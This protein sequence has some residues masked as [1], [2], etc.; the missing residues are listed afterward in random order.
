M[1][2]ED[3]IVDESSQFRREILADR[4]RQLTNG[5]RM[6]VEGRESDEHVN[7]ALERLQREET[8]ALIEL[9]YLSHADSVA[10]FSRR[11][12]T[13][14]IFTEL[15]QYSVFERLPIF[16]RVSIANSLKKGKPG[17]PR[18]HRPLPSLPSPH[19]FHSTG[20][21]LHNCLADDDELITTLLQ[22]L[23]RVLKA[24]KR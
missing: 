17:A 12:T 21:R 4:V 16:I 5:I 20:H 13:F 15:V 6:I 11:K 7:D 22:L 10:F 14:M 3:V 23:Y 2:S 9:I 24:C 19:R 8:L 18:V 1:R